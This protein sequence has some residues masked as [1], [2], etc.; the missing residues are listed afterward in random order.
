[1]AC[2]AV[3]DVAPFISVPTSPSQRRRLSV[4]EHRVPSP[5]RIFCNCSTQRMPHFWQLVDSHHDQRPAARRPRTHKAD[6]WAPAVHTHTQRE[7][8]TFTSSASTLA[9]PLIEV[10]LFVSWRAFEC[11]ARVNE[12]RYKTGLHTHT[13]TRERGKHTLVR[14]TCWRWPRATKSNSVNS[15]DLWACN[16]FANSKK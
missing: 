12:R 10:S 1:M 4:D 13:H 3:R 9:A 7:R 2:A 14:F 6:V 16:Q 5:R 8:P 15:L 11:D